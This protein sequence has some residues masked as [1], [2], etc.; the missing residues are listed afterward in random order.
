MN[1]NVNVNPL[2][3]VKVRDKNGHMVTRWMRVL[4]ETGETAITVPAPAIPSSPE[5]VESTMWRLFPEFDEESENM[6]DIFGQYWDY[7]DVF[8]RHAL[9]LLPPKTM[10]QLSDQFNDDGS[11]AQCFL[12][13]TA[14]E[15]VIAM[16]E[17]GSEE[18]SQV[19]YDKAVRKL[20]NALVFREVLSELT[21]VCNLTRTAGDMNYTLN[22]TLANYEH[23]GPD[24]L[25]DEKVLSDTDYSK[26]PKHERKKA[27]A[28]V[29]AF[30]LN[31]YFRMDDGGTELPSPEFVEFIRENLD[32]Q[33]QVIELVETRRTNDVSVLKEMFASDAPAL[34]SG[35]L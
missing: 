33:R 12:A 9:G 25:H 28:F 24:P 6:L 4:E 7:T 3:Q 19:H 27:V 29:I 13:L 21:E 2:K 16:S 18:D 26:A 30:N 10:Q 8:T 32:R 1:A 17:R 22:M 35:V 20:N 34:V 5:I 14:Y 11:G 23:T 15:Y 31:Q